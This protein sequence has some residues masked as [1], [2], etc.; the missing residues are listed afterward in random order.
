MSDYQRL[1]A[2]SKQANASMMG[3]IIKGAH[4]ALS[5]THRKKVKDIPVLVLPYRDLEAFAIN[6]DGHTVIGYSQDV[7]FIVYRLLK[8]V[9]AVVHPDRFDLNEACAR[10][11]A[12]GLY[13]ATGGKTL[14]PREPTL[15]STPFFEK[16]GYDNTFK[17]AI[18]YNAASAAHF[19]EVWVLLHEYFH[20][21][22]RH[23]DIA[24]EELEKVEIVAEGP[25]YVEAYPVSIQQ[26][27][28]ADSTVFKAL[29][30]SMRDECRRFLPI[31]DIFLS[32]LDIARTIVNE[33]YGIGR[34]THPSPLER[35]K[36]VRN[37]YEQE[38]GESHVY[39]WAKEVGKVFH[40][41]KRIY[42][43]MDKGLKDQLEKSHYCDSEKKNEANSNA[44]YF[45][46]K[47]RISLRRI[48]PF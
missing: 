26:E 40:K 41:V 7:S 12:M 19:I 9:Y 8:H 32:Q 35:Q 29:L 5:S 37:I 28:E 43:D 34:K 47:L 38:F 13:I 20:I 11:F 18:E 4:N 25:F 2:V 10:F 48:L 3:T 36:T 33:K 42:V 23:L 1:L 14:I 24:M 39:D 21:I 27:I 45:M 16:L 17:G 44:V 30:N 15:W 46:N 6:A 31:Y 22:C